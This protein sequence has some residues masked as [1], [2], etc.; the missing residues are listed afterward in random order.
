MA[1]FRLWEEHMTIERVKID[2]SKLLDIRQFY[3]LVERVAKLEWEVS[4]LRRQVEYA[5]IVREDKWVSE[6]DERRRTMAIKV[7]ATPKS[8]QDNSKIVHQG[9]EA[10]SFGPVRQPK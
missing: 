6:V 9:G 1:C 10:P 4:F 5:R 2:T 3:A 7:K 8:A